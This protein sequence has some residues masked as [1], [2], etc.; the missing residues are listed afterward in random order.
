MINDESAW[1]AVLSAVARPVDLR[2]TD[3]VNFAH[4]S[5][6]DYDSRVRRR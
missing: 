3:W 1:E 5:Y 4:Y 6:H 2:D